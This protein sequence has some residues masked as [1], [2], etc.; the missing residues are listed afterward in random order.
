MKKNSK[1]IAIA[2]AASLCA[3]FAPAV[4]PSVTLPL[5]AT[6]EAQVVSKGGLT[7]EE[8]REGVLV[9]V[10]SSKPADKVYVPLSDPEVPAE[11]VYSWEGVDYPMYLERYGNSPEGNRKAYRW[12]VGTES[13]NRGDACNLAWEE[14]SVSDRSLIRHQVN[15]FLISPRANPATDEYVWGTLEHFPGGPNNTLTNWRFPFSIGQPLYNVV[16]DIEFPRVAADGSAVTAPRIEPHAYHWGA[17]V[18]L[19][20]TGETVSYTAYHAD[21]ANL[22]WHHVAPANI[23]FDPSDPYIARVTYPFI[24]ENSTTSFQFSQISENVSSPIA[25][26]ATITADKVCYPQAQVVQ[27]EKIEVFEGDPNEPNAAIQNATFDRVDGTPE[28]IQVNPADGTLTVAPGFNVAPGEYRVPVAV[29]YAGYPPT[30]ATALIT[31]LPAI[32]YDDSMVKPGGTTK[33]YPQ[34][35]APYPGDTRFELDGDW[36]VPEGWTVTVDL[37]TGRV[38]VAVAEDIDLTDLEKVQIPVVVTFPAKGDAQGVTYETTADVTV[39]NDAVIKSV[40]ETIENGVPVTIITLIDGREIRIP[41]GQDGQDGKDGKDGQDGGS[42]IEGSSEL[43]D[44]CIATGL[45]LGLPLLALIPLGLANQVGIPG[46]ASAQAQIGD[47]I[48]DFNNN[49]QSQIGVFNPS[50]ARQFESINS[51]LQLAGPGIAMV[52]VALLAGGLLYDACLPEGEGSI[53]DADS[54][55]AEELDASSE[56]SNTSELSSGS[57]E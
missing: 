17:S 41:K 21:D 56:E 29:N 28:W 24:P 11:K 45:G 39:I 46:L 2:A 47:M 54:S 52:A 50:L 3:S 36:E 31:V 10:D 5:T 35:N 42:T 30:T 15:G 48:Q 7:A 13:G 33:V 53:S 37:Y 23:D 25:A 27:G 6:A 40:V 55:N 32:G 22:P 34:N 12:V 16:V 19:Q 51:Q 26:R 49:L 1:F 57:S 14:Y 18:E 4:A 44:R 38:D 20:S 43:S 9:V 8:V